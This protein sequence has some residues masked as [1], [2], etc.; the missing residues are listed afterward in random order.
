MMNSS[1]PACLIP[2]TPLPTLLTALPDLGRVAA[3]IP[4]EAIADEQRGELH[5]LLTAPDRYALQV[6]DDSMLD[7]G[8]F[9][10]DIVVVQSQQQ[11]RDNDIVVG[12]VDNEQVILK[13]IRYR[14]GNRV[15][16]LADG[17]GINSRVLDQS[18]VIIQGKVVGQVRRYR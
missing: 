4:L 9:A 5:A 1:W 13:R 18:R 8:I 11:A 3:G 7:A 6:A 15:E 10:G 12:L 17:H 14:P 16:L 2:V